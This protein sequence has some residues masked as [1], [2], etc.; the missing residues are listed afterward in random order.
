MSE[1]ERIP[2]SATGHSRAFE[3][4]VSGPD[5]IIGLLAYA[6]YKQ[7]VREEAI[8]GAPT[9]GALRN[10]S[11]ISVGMFRGSAEQLLNSF[12][13]NAI[14]EA[15]PDILNSA[16]MGAVAEVG[17][18]LERHID[19]RTGFW[20]AVVTNLLAWVLTVSIT[21]VLLVGLSITRVGDRLMERF[22]NALIQSQD[23]STIPPD[24]QPRPAR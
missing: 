14:D 9:N 22:T 21:V 1:A 15:K 11:A 7:H 19:K 20:T 10:P 18:G 13:S 8:G 5:D 3:N 24:G 6:L 2:G 4:L 16:V 23:A 17:N 12:A